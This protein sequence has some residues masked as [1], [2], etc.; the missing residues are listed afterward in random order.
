MSIH[1]GSLKRWESEEKGKVQSGIFYSRRSSRWNIL[2]V[3]L[4]FYSY[5][6]DAAQVDMAGS[7]R[8]YRSYNRCIDDKRRLSGR[9]YSF[10]PE[11]RNRMSPF[12][13][14][15]ILS[16]PSFNMKATSGTP[17]SSG[18]QASSAFSKDQGSPTREPRRSTYGGCLTCRVF[19]GH[20]RGGPRCLYSTPRELL[21]VLLLEH[22]HCASTKLVWSWDIEAGKTT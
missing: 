18:P 16:W 4:L 1:F 17:I 10:Y 7:L 14:W 12:A 19:V 3:A 15:V 21:S 6:P 2:A 13:G 20:P 11:Y 22:H 5:H 8:V 9:Q